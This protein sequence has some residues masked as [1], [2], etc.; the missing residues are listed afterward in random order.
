LVYP[1]DLGS[2][3][4]YKAEEMEIT[5]DPHTREAIR[6]EYIQ[7]IKDQGLILVPDHVG[8]KALEIMKEQEQLL[9]HKHLTPYQIAKHGLI[10]GITTLKTIKNMIADGRIGTNEWYLD[11]GGKYHILT[12]A[13]KRLRHAS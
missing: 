11:A 12:Q 6:R 9:K 3:R 5:L 4:I 8:L 1:V 7:A 10:P 2:H 13:I